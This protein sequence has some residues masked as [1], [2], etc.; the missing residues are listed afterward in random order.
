MFL[1]PK[2]FWGVPP[3]KEKWTCIIKRTQIHI[4]WQSFK[5]IGRGSSEN[6]W[7]KKINKEKTPRV[8]HG[9]GWPNN[10]NKY[11]SYGCICLQNLHYNHPDND[12]RKS[13]LF[14]LHSKALRQEYMDSWAPNGCVPVVLCGQGTPFRWISFYFDHQVWLWTLYCLAQ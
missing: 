8:K 5:A 14:K 12:F 6:V 3:P 7:R 11:L 10:N 9:W 13:N 1:A 2:F 4:M